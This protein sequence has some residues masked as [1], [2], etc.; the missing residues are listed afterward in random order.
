MMEWAASANSGAE[1]VSP[2]IIVGLRYR[3]DAASVKGRMSA[4]GPR[5]V[6]HFLQFSMERYVK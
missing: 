4:H 3:C 2:S 6:V 5:R 1:G